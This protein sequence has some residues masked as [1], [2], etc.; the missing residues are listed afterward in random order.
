[1][2]EEVAAGAEDVAVVADVAV[3]VTVVEEETTV[4]AAET[5][6]LSAV[7]ADGKLLTYVCPLLSI[8][9]DT[10]LHSYF[11]TRV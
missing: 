7:T 6:H 5:L 4:P 8:A 11:M 1:M 9:G 2:V 10:S 3:V